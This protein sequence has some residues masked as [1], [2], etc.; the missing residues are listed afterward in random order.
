MRSFPPRYCHEGV[1]DRIARLLFGFGC[2]GAMA[3]ARM[4]NGNVVRARGRWRGASATGRRTGGGVLYRATS[5]V[6]TVLCRADASILDLVLRYNVISIRVSARR[7]ARAPGVGSKRNFRILGAN[8]RNDVNI[9]KFLSPAKLAQSPLGRGKTAKFSPGARSAPLALRSAPGR[10]HLLNARKF[11]DLG[12]NTRNP[13]ARANVR[14]L[15]GASGVISKNPSWRN[16]INDRNITIPSI[17][18]WTA[19]DRSD[20][21]TLFP[22]GTS[23]VQLAVWYSRSVGQSRVYT[24][25]GTVPGTVGYGYLV[26]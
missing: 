10:L 16:A 9:A 15:G 20:G 19:H 24:W 4:A 11:L 5:T 22:M 2:I 14:N 8:A 23:T 18:G 1:S 7:A 6:A 26:L 3:R 12:A 17:F 21:L 13:A 25:Y